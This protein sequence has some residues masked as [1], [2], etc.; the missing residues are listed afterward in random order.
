MG[1]VLIEKLLRTCHELDRIFVLLRPKRQKQGKDRLADLINC[2]LFDVVRWRGLLHKLE[3]VEGDVTGKNLGIDDPLMMERLLATV[4]VVF[5]SA[6]TVKFDEPLAQAVNIN[7]KGTRNV[8][9]LCRRMPQ[10]AAIVHVSTAYA[11]CEH[12]IV[13][14][15][16]YTP[17]MTPEALI[18][19]SELLTPEQFQLLRSKLLG[20]KPN[21]YTY[22]KAMAESWL[23]RFARDLPL[24]IC[25]PSI[26]MAT[27]REPFPG[28]VDNLNG[29]S[30]IIAAMNQ[31]I[32]K[33]VH[34]G[35]DEIS[36]CIPV[37]MLINQMVTLGWFANLYA[38]T[39]TRSP[40]MSRRKR[41]V[42]LSSPSPSEDGDIQSNHESGYSSKRGS[43]P[44]RD[45]DIEQEEDRFEFFYDNLRE[46]EKLGPLQ[47]Q[48]YMQ[49]IA[50]YEP[51]A[52]RAPS[53]AS[54]AWLYQRVRLFRD[55]Y[56]KNLQESATCP[57]DLHRV[58]IPVFNFASVRKN[59]ITFGRCVDLCLA[60]GAM[61][62]PSTAIRSLWV[63]VQD[64]K[65]LHD[66]VC[67]VYHTIPALVFDAVLTVMG[68]KPYL[69]RLYERINK[70]TQ[71]LRCFLCNSWDFR[72]DNSDF[73]Y[74][75]IMSLDDRRLFDY[76]LAKVDWSVHLQNHCLGLR[77]FVHKE[78]IENVDRAR[79][80]IDKVIY[81]NSVFEVIICVLMAAIFY[82][83]ISES[84]Y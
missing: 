31:G 82:Y 18:Q 21:T 17:T 68:R 6:A 5:H 80:N 16:I 11:N 57:D 75:H 26:V 37:D 83:L 62:P 69:A 45:I 23:L 84:C 66:V 15:Q 4:S 79:Q 77:E 14:E 24:V 9:E 76:D 34:G 81:R 52:A 39:K 36:D 30:G 22:T 48:S 63:V 8:I 64:R 2:P 3:V 27:Y 44:S 53:D 20:K 73:M 74:E 47:A 32:L 19:L 55:H 72:I 67:M 7:L 35:R 38:S 50:C 59:P 13:S 10:L 41:S 28:W 42:S 40:I 71:V 29:P 25:R 1:R 33:S 49:E 61:F 78:P 12:S 60:N 54:Q 46:S 58:D 70:G 43:L 65:L 51:S 56:L